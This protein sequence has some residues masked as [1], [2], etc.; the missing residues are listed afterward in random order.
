MK[1]ITLI[2]ILG[3]LAISAVAQDFDDI[4]YT[5]KKEKKEQTVVKQRRSTTPKADFDYVPAGLYDGFSPSAYEDNRDIDEYNRRG[6]FAINDTVGIA[7]DSLLNTEEF[8]Y[9]SRI[10]KFHNPTIANDDEVVAQYLASQ[11]ADVNITIINPGYYGYW[12]S[13]Y[14]YYYDPFYW[15]SWA[16]PGVWSPAWSWNWGPSWNWWGPSWA[17]NPYYGPSWG[18]AWTWGGGWHPGPG[19]GFNPG[20]HPGGGQPSY[21]Y[22]PQR[23]E[24]GR[25]PGADGYRPGSGRYPSGNGTSTRPGSTTRPG[26]GTVDRRPSSNGSSFDNTTNN[27]SGSYS[28]PG[29]NGSGSSSFG[30]GSSGRGGGYSGGGSSRGGGGG[31][32]G[33][34]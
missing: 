22:H 1:R 33:R 16:W 8:A 12:G 27:N 20:H 23:P 25:R 10:K 17:W 19:P 21:G 30:S 9:T 24:S 15:N 13:P 4:Y 18:W 6:I 28:R 3:M 32:G 2:S 26:N 11:G 14:N 34:H 31:R 7:A 29:R 5:P